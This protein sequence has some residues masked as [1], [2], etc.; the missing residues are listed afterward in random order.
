MLR[1]A[2]FTTALVFTAF[3]FGNCKQD[4]P[5][6]VSQTDAWSID[7]VALRE[8]RKNNWKDHGCDLITQEEIQKIFN[9]DGKAL[10][11]NSRPLPN[12]AFCLHTWNR[13]DWKE[14]EAHNEK[15]ASNFL[16]TRN[17]LVVQVFNYGNGLH[18][19]QQF[20]NLKRDRRDTYEE[21]V[22]GLGDD[23]LWGTTIVTL[24]VKKGD[25]VLSITL[26]AMDNPHDNLPKAK[27]VAQLAL[28][29]L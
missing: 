8:F 10:S 7:T 6:A 2:L 14:R 18:S 16:P 17:S 3:I 22:S 23:A 25:S 5:A 27:E 28:L 13:P 11:L 15:D 26:D 1:S 4:K 20:D 19:S 9:I 29:K 12:Q 21:S 24:L